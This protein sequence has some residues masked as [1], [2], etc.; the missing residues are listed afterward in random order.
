MLCKHLFLHLLGKDVSV[1]GQMQPFIGL[2]KTPPDMTSPPLVFAVFALKEN[3]VRL[4][5]AGLF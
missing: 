5:R 3:R 2:D 4:H 1:Y